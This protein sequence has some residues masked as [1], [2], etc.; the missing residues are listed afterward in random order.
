MRDR[1]S[2]GV[3]MGIR[4]RAWDILP[5]SQEYISVMSPCQLQVLVR[6]GYRT[7]ASGGWIGHL[8][9]STARQGI[10][11]SRGGQQVI[12]SCLPTPT[13]CAI[14]GRHRRDSGRFSRSNTREQLGFCTPLAPRAQAGPT[15]ARGRP[16]KKIG[17]PRGGWVG[18][19]T[20][21]D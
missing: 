1:V 12:F 2:S 3:P 7:R 11:A 18:Q 4:R 16:Q 15:G 17:D 8:K 6:P 10:R 19:G 21:K 20:K 5:R 13:S 14:R 9:T